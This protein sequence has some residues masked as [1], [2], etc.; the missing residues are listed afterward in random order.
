VSS[1]RRVLIE[2][3]ELKFELGNIEP[4]FCILALYDIAKKLRISEN[5]YFHLNSA[6]TQ[7]L[8]GQKIRTKECRKALFSVSYPSPDIF[9]VVRIEKVLQGVNYDE[10]VE[11]YIKY[12]S[13]R[14]KDKEKILRDV[15]DTCSRLGRWRQP[16]CVGMLPLFNISDDKRDLT[17]IAGANVQSKEKDFPPTVSIMRS[18]YRYKGDVGDQAFFEQLPEKG[19]RSSKSMKPLSGYL[20]L[21]IKEV[22]LQTPAGRAPSS[23]QINTASNTQSLPVLYDSVVSPSLLPLHPDKKAPATDV[24]THTHSLSFIDEFTYLI[25]FLSISDEHVLLC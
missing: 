18:F 23:S 22:L 16:F 1:V 15:K 11:P 10:V 21:D 14:D 17:V 2:P 5:F 24:H 7:G 20:A 25:V 8:L 3:K 9:I 12:D 4:Y 19:S 13:L 6:E